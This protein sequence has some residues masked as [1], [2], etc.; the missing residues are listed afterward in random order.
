MGG[1]GALRADE[2]TEVGERVGP[3]VLGDGGGDVV[4]IGEDLVLELVLLIVVVLVGLLLDLLAGLAA[5]ELVGLLGGEGGALLGGDAL[6]DVAEPAE[7]G[8]AAHAGLLDLGLEGLGL[9]GG[10]GLALA[11]EDGAALG[12]DLLDGGKEAV[13]QVLA[14]LP[15]DVD[16]LGDEAGVVLGGAPPELLLEDLVLEVLVVAELEAD[17]DGARVAVLAVLELEA[18]D[19]DVLEGGQEEGGVLGLDVLVNLG[20]R[21]LE[22]EGPEVGDLG[23][24]G[25]ALLVQRARELVLAAD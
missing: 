17:G 15:V 6:A 25:G 18:G 4:A 13:G 8:N 9:G 20:G 1:G 5:V 22:D 19:G 10:G 16:G 14:G 3:E 11:G 2:L 7:E 12:P 23:D 21:L 24:D